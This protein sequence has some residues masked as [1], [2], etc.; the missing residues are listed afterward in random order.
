MSWWHIAVVKSVIAVDYLEISG[1]VLMGETEESA[2]A[3]CQGRAEHGGWGSEAAVWP[4][5]L[6]GFAAR[7]EFWFI[8]AWGP[9]R[10]AHP[11]KVSIIG[12][13][14]HELSVSHGSGL[15]MLSDIG[16]LSLF[17]SLT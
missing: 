15:T 16:S 1:V 14:G 5:M 13:I 17:H 2:S 4:L 10:V 9:T 8:G 6:F 3:Q 7:Q 11:F 12:A